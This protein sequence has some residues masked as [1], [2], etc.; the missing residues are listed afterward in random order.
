MARR[1]SLT[2]IA[3]SVAAI[4]AHIPLDRLPV[5]AAVAACADDCLRGDR[6]LAALRSTEYAWS[7][8]A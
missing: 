6:L 3:T 7:A 1:S 4:A 5:R 2:W 8:S